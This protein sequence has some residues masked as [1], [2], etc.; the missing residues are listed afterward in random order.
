MDWRLEPLVGSSTVTSP[1]GMD[2]GSPN[3]T[4]CRIEYSSAFGSVNR[5]QISSIGSMR[6]K[7]GTAPRA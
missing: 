5:V 1:A 7:T 6:R 4:I 2:S 3:L